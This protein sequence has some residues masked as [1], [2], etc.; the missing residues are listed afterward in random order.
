MKA[1][2]TS[3]RA[4]VLLAL[5]GMVWG[6]VMA[7]SQDH[8][9]MPAHA[10]LNLLGWVSLFLFGIFYRLNPGIDRSRSARIQVGVWI[11]ATVV[12]T[13]GVALEH[14]GNPAGDPIAAIGSLA[15]LADMVLFGWLV[16]RHERNADVVGSKPMPAE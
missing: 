3:F 2:S 13:T 5:V 8:S 16:L 11:V 14:S 12:L 7:I 15:V 10:H 6:I 4:A 1:S 9:T